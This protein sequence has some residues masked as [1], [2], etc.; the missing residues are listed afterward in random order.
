MISAAEIG[1]QNS[2]ALMVNRA[3]KTGTGAALLDH[4]TQ[5][6]Q[7]EQYCSARPQA[8]GYFACGYIDLQFGGFAPER[9]RAQARQWLCSEAPP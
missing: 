1:P 8:R 9:H 3:V 6:G 7:G 5:L 4:P 2:P